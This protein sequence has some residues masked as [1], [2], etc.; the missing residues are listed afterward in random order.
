M[1]FIFFENSNVRL[2]HLLVWSSAVQ[3]SP[4]LNVRAAGCQTVSYVAMEG[5]ESTS[6][7]IMQGRMAVRSDLQKRSTK[8]RVCRFPAKTWGPQLSASKKTDGVIEL[9]GRELRKC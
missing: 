6:E 1:S 9:D 4:N 2:E 3:V 7:Q 5:E 8:D